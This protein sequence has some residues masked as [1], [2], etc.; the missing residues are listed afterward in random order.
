MMKKSKRLGLAMV[1]GVVMTCAIVLGSVF[2][3]GGA[4]VS[5]DLIM[6]QPF[7]G[8]II[9]ETAPL[10]NLDG[11]YNADLIAELVY[12][13]ENAERGLPNLHADHTGV[14]GIEVSDANHI[15][16]AN[17][18]TLPDIR[19]FE[20]HG[21]FATTGISNGVLSDQSR[22][23][24]THSNWR[25]VYITH[26]DG[27][28][29]PV[30]T[31]R[32]VEAFRNNVMHPVIDD[33][34]L[35]VRYEN[36]QLRANLVDEFDNVLD[37][38]DDPLQMREH[39][40]APGNLPGTWQSNQPSSGT[41]VNQS[42]ESGGLGDLIWLPSIVEIAGTSGQDLWRLTSDERSHVQNG[43]STWAWLRAGHSTVT[44]ARTTEA[45]GT[46]QRADAD[47]VNLTRAIVPAVH[48]SLTHLLTYANINIGF[49]DTSSRTA[50][51]SEN[52]ITIERETGVETII[53]DA[54]Q[55]NTVQNIVIGTG[56]NQFTLTPTDA[57]TVTENALGKFEI[58]Y[59]DNGR[60]VHLELSEIAQGFNIV[61]NTTNNWAVTRTYNWPTGFGLAASPSDSTAIAE[62]GFTTAIG[63]PTAPGG[64]RFAGWWTTP[65]IGGAEVTSGTTVAN[66]G[67]TETVDVITQIYAR[68]DQNQ[69]TVI[70][71]NYDGTTENFGVQNVVF[72]GVVGDP[73]VEPTDQTLVF[74]GWW[75]TDGSGSGIWGTRVNPN[76]FITEA[77]N[78]TTIEI[79]AR[80]QLYVPRPTLS[81][82]NLS[83]G[84][85]TW[86]N[87][88]GA[89]F[90]VSVNGIDRP[91][92]TGNLFDFS[93]L[94]PGSHTIS[95][96][97]V[98]SNG[99]ESDAL[100][101]TVDIPQPITVDVI[102][103]SENVQIGTTQVLEDKEDRVAP[104]DPERTGWQFMG[105]E[106]AAP[107]QDSNG[108]WVFVF[109]AIWAQEF[110]VVFMNGIADDS[111]QIGTSQVVY[112]F[113]NIVTPQDPERTGF[114]F[115]GWSR[116]ESGA[117]VTYTA[118]WDRNPVLTVR[119]ERADG[120][121]YTETTHVITHNPTAPG[122]ITEDRTVGSDTFTFVRWDVTTTT[123]ATTGDRMHTFTAIW[124]LVVLPPSTTLILASI[125]AI[126]ADIANLDENN[127]T[128]ASWALFEAAHA[129]IT[130]NNTMTLVELLEAY[131]ALNQAKSLL[132]ENPVHTP[133]T[134]TVF[135]GYNAADFG[136]NRP[137]IGQTRVDGE[138]TYRLAGWNVTSATAP[139]GDVTITNTAIWELVE[140][141]THIPTFTETW[142]GY[143][144]ARPALED[145]R[146][147]NG[148]EQVL[149]RWDTVTNT[150]SNGDVTVTHTAVWENVEQD[151]SNFLTDMLPWILIGGAGLLVLI[152]VAFFAM[153]IAKNRRKVART[154]K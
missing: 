21:T 152:S 43:F 77:Q 25:L 54:G 12:L 40:V 119:V 130:H 128:E 38:F 35:D 8:P 76:T 104:T 62:N 81:G 127:F 105:W 146:N 70:R 148:V 44:N 133:T 85:I 9:T 125:S 66:R 101:I 49:T 36:S 26:P 83:G 96:R 136:G 95:I 106:L 78:S 120:T 34:N 65:S 88:I 153:A 56:A 55:H 135:T 99:D 31:F 97:T 143:T 37:L 116:V 67:N 149:V 74:G 154:V 41:S 110:T 107:T 64:H 11:S 69:A 92:Q 79:F 98:A 132:Q 71:V 33:W 5:A 3:V 52:R 131:I 84:T 82:L 113:A 68:W 100:T 151:D 90:L 111:Q 18:G 115:G 124:E 58:Y 129:A 134:T 139:N 114:T 122:P 138:D 137:T 63:T 60:V 144:G 32:M 142:T 28:G 29:D 51:S 87:I 15:R 46:A 59:T 117:T 23:N 89:E 22:D 48:L 112:D 1:I 123:D 121:Q 145:T 150:A 14:S 61:A 45:L 20:S 118:E 73:T 10:F 7:D 50:T 57:P 42:F 2:Q 27:G 30:F 4:R 91:M 86:A 24:F 13:A 108:R 147:F 53:F 80:W 16:T 94:A 47:N 140:E 75:T 17:D 72:A 19:L 93:D 39:F 109:N 6:P 102:Y 103:R 141:S 126:E